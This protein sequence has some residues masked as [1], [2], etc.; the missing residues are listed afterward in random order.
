MS[1]T[2]TGT[3]GTPDSVSVLSV[4]ITTVR[5]IDGCAMAKDHS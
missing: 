4:G 5:G 2:N 1:S 3:I